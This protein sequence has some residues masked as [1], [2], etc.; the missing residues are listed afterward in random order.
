MAED[1]KIIEAIYR[2]THEQKLSRREIAR[3]LHVCRRTIRKYLNNPLAKAAVREPRP[4][5]LDPFKPVIRELLD[6]WPR[7]SSVTIG[8]RIQSLG[9]TR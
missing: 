7:A 2:M 6:Q 5:K 1:P 3:Q 4:S 9:Y 8:Q